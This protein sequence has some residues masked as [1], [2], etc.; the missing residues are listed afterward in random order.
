M[1]VKSLGFVENFIP[2]LYLLR[3]LHC[4]VKPPFNVSLET[5]DLNTELEKILNGVNWGPRLL[6]WV[7]GE[8]VL[9][10]D[11]TLRIIKWGFH[12]M[13][14]LSE[15]VSMFRIFWSMGIVLNRAFVLLHVFYLQELLWMGVHTSQYRSICDVHSAVLLLWAIHDTNSTASCLPQILCSKYYYLFINGVILGKSQISF[16]PYNEYCLTAVYSTSFFAWF[17]VTFS[18]IIDCIVFL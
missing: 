17:Y 13:Y 12:F 7:H 11:L 16:F 1:W 5:V 4:T 3:I 10:E 14:K 9:R 18:T 15:S 6:T 2:Y 8:W